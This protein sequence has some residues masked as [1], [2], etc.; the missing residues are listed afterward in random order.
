MANLKLCARCINIYNQP[1]LFGKELIFLR[2]YLDHNKTIKKCLILHFLS[3]PKQ[4]KKPTFKYPYMRGVLDFHRDLLKV[5][6]SIDHELLSEIAL[7][8][9]FDDPINIQF[10]SGTTGK[11]KGTVLTHHSILNN[12]FFVGERLGYTE[13]DVVCIPVP[14]HLS[15]RGLSPCH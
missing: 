2:R 1:I 3:H 12:G 13:N 15:H 5:S 4:S 10:T 6:R 8:Q 11:P 14:L 7:N 9:D